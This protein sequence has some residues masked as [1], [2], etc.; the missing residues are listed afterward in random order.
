MTSTRA[1]ALWIAVA[2]VGCGQPANAGDA[3]SDAALSVPSGSCS[4]PGDHGNDIGV[5][6]FCTPRGSECAATSQAQLCLA[7]VAPAEGQWFC[8]R[9]CTSDAQ[10]GTGAVCDGD[11][12]GSAC[13]PARCA[14]PPDDAG[15]STDTGGADG[16]APDAGPADAGA[17]VDAG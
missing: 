7:Q 9:L 6:E 11:G 12:R 1:L 16:A 17:G 3:G 8:T 10:C 13:I 15:V 14:P 4:Q 5:G 2:S